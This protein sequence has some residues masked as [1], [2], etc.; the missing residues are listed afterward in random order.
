[1]FMKIFIKTQICLIFDPVNK[2]V[3]GKME[4]EF[5]GKI[6]QEFVGLKPKM[7]SQVTV[8]NEEIKKAKGVNDNVVK[9]IRHRKYTDVLFHKKWKEL[10][11]NYMKLELMMFVKFNCLALVSKDMYQ[12]MTLVV[13]LIFI[14]I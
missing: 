13:S 9:N 2:K 1:M 8:D 10:K 11:V 12:V 6:I 14:K 3:I 5:K 7:Y 4:D